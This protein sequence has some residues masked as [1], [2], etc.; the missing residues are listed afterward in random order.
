MYYGEHSVGEGGESACTTFKTFTVR[1]K[2]G[3]Q[4]KEL[5]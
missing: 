1:F 4:H 2:T 3:V 5:L